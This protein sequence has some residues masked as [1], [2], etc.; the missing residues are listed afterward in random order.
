MPSYIVVGGQW[1][2]EGKGSI[3]AYLAMHD[4]PEVIARGGVGTN[5][6]HSVFINGRKYAVRQL[7]TGFMQTEARLLVGAGFL[8][9]SEVFFSGV[10]D[11]TDFSGAEGTGRSSRCALMG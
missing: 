6:G 9:E 10:E 1:G 2:D 7:P 5:A 3:I 11:L 8:W 4:K